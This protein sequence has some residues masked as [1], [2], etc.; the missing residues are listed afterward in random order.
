MGVVDFVPGIFVVFFSLF[1]P[2][3]PLAPPPPP[4]ISLCPA[5]GSGKQAQGHFKREPNRPKLLRGPPTPGHSCPCHVKRGIQQ[6]KRAEGK[7]GGRGQN[8][9][10]RS[11]MAKSDRPCTRC[12]ASTAGRRRCRGRRLPGWP[13][14]LRNMS[15]PF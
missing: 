1:V 4:P 14:A 3:R 12:V 13:K 5:R 15:A 6:I 8:H 9:F 10:F 7:L 2:V 11:M